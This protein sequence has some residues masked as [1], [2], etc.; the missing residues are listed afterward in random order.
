MINR[1]KFVGGLIAVAIVSVIMF[2]FSGRNYLSFLNTWWVQLIIA[3]VALGLIFYRRIFRNNTVQSQHVHILDAG[4]SREYK[5][6]L[7]TGCGLFLSGILWSLLTLL[8]ATH[9][10]ISPAKGA[11]VV[12]L[13]AVLLV[14]AGTAILIYGVISWL[15]R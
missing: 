1:K 3:A 15:W 14:I 12:I 11:V 8:A 5:L 10:Q 9:Y 4:K 7:L 6:V 13:P 2:S